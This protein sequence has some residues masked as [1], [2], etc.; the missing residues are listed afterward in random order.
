MQLVWAYIS[1]PVNGRISS[2]L[3][4]RY[5]KLV[6]QEDD[7]IPNGDLPLELTRASCDDEIIIKKVRT[8]TR[9][10]CSGWRRT[11]LQYKC[12]LPVVF[13]VVGLYT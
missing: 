2:E 10:S 12:G 9:T 6:M 4:L 13:Q 11:S 7:E 1:I 3:S 8:W 5:P